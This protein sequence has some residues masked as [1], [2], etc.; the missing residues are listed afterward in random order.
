MSVGAVDREHAVSLLIELGRLSA[1]HVSETAEALSSLSDFDAMNRLGPGDWFGLCLSLSDNDLEHL[2]KGAVLAEEGLSWCGGSVAAAIWILKAM[3]RRG[4]KAIDWLADWALRT[5]T[6]P[7]VPFGTQNL[8]ARSL[9]EYLERLAGKCVTYTR[10]I[11]N[12][13]STQSERTTRTAE[14]VKRAERHRI[15]AQARRDRIAELRALPI[16]D[17]LVVAIDDDAHRLSYYP[18]E[19]VSEVDDATLEALDGERST[20]LVSKSASIHRGA[21]CGF[22]GVKAK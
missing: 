14:S 17:R 12:E 2:F 20:R 15:Q 8:G 10:Y 22:A 9:I 11:K 16:L 3:E 5:S 19:W 6:N 7:Y 13:R 4:S 21:W 1:V 18:Q